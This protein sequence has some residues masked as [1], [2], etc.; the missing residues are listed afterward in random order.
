MSD[1]RELMRE[2][3]QLRRCA[4]ALRP[5]AT[6]QQRGGASRN[7]ELAPLEIP[8]PD[9]ETPVRCRIETRAGQTIGV[10]VV[11]EPTAL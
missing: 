11:T 9:D 2:V 3:Y 5:T 8:I 6:L 10:T 7:L 4:G 1:P